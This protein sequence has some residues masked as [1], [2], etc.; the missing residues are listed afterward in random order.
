MNQNLKQVIKQVVTE[1]VDHN[2]GEVYQKT[3]ENISYLPTEP[4][5]VKVYLD[6]IA[7]L[8]GL[9]KAGSNLLHCLLRK[10]D[11]DGIITLVAASKKRIADEL[12]IKPQTV[13][14]NIQ[15]LIKAD[16][17]KRSG[18]GEFMFNPMLFAKGEWKNIYKQRNKY[19]ELTLTYDINGERTIS[20]KVK[21]QQELP[22]D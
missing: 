16:I 6:D 9:P 14:N 2:S 3:T 18:R 4:P 12:S 11:Y 10:M 19:V 13:A 17:L 20:G 21:N 5:F 8:Y 1:T 22:L 15:A 7:K